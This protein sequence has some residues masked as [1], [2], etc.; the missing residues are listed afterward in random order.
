MNTSSISDKPFRDRRGRVVFRGDRVMNLR[1]SLE[2]VVNNIIDG[3][4]IDGVRFD[5]GVRQMCSMSPGETELI[6]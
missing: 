1:T 6:G 2:F 4:W 3:E 5:D